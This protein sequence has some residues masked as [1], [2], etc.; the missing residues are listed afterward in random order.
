MKRLLNRFVLAVLLAGCEFSEMASADQVSACVNKKTGVMRVAT[1]CKKRENI[2]I[3]NTQGVAGPQGIAGPQGPQGEQG[4]PGP[5]QRVAA[6]GQVL[7]G[8][9]SARYVANSGGFVVA[10]AS[11][12]VP[13]PNG[14]AAPTLEYVAGVTPTATCPGV[15]QSTAG[16]LCVYGY[17]LSNVTSVT[18]SGG[19]N[20][21]NSLHGFSLDVFFNAASAGYILASWAYQV[22]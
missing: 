10:G 5:L 4:P 15:G 16:R 9:L 13:L 7:T 19:F 12:P 6:S 1:A 17:N 22:P 8:Q 18:T 20:A 2:L 3:F 21:D 11:Y 14:T